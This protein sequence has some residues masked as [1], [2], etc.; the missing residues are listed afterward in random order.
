[1]RVCVFAFPRGRKKLFFG[2][3][4]LVV[5][6]IF[7]FF[8]SGLCR[9]FFFFFFF[10]FCARRGW[11]AGG[12]VAGEMLTPDTPAA[13]R[14]PPSGRIAQIRLDYADGHVVSDPPAQQQAA[15]D[16]P[17]TAVSDRMA[18]RLRRLDQVLRPVLTVL[19]I[20]K[21]PTELLP[22]SVRKLKGGGGCERRQLFRQPANHVDNFLRKLYKL[23]E[24]LLAV[25]RNFSLDENYC[26]W[27]DTVKKGNGY[28]S[29]ASSGIAGRRDNVC[30]DVILSK[31]RRESSFTANKKK[32][33]DANSGGA[34]NGSQVPT[35]GKARILKE[36]G[37]RRT[38]G[39]TASR[40]V[41]PLKRVSCFGPCLKFSAMMQASGLCAYLLFTYVVRSLQAELF[42]KAY[43]QTLQQVLRDSQDYE[44]CLNKVL[45]L[46]QQLV[47]ED[48]DAK[49]AERESS[50]QDAPWF[51]P[52]YHCIP[53]RPETTTKAALGSRRRRLEGRPMAKACGSSRRR[54]RDP[55]IAARQTEF[56][57]LQR[58][59]LIALNR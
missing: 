40:L 44:R 26:N 33:K 10:L 46:K 43:D 58:S 38:S 6:T 13:R 37:G 35:R 32:A 50:F 1:M 30:L 55:V 2:S 56:D 14:N 5:A 52:T 4:S 3:L 21:L 20:P 48:E 17:E 12:R 41:V 54:I 47:Q 27:A 53:H 23:E 31:F 25:R 24:Q 22:A 45:D 42:E 9:L 11:R 28:L 57:A 49:A 34:T 51:P 59:M 15:R 7:L 36:R 18:E 16:A 19:E 8:V 29:T 39:E